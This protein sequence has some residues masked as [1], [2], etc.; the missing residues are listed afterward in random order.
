V[1]SCLDAFQSIVTTIAV[2]IGAYAALSGLNTWREQLRG[3]T[4][5]ELARRLMR[6]ALD[7]RDMANSFRHPAIG[8]GEMLDALR[9][10]GIDPAKVDLITDKRATPLVYQRRW[11]RVAKAMS[12][13]HVEILEAEVLWGD[14]PRECE[15]GLRRAVHPLWAAMT[16]R[17]GRERPDSPQDEGARKR[18][19]E[20]FHII[21]AGSQEPDATAEAITAA[22][23]AF[24]AVVKPHLT[25]RRR[26]T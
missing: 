4:E 14:S 6:S 2:G 7:V 12:D 15:E 11:S 23:R 18:E 13:L 19:Q 1:S 16:M 21:Y 22:V 3:K 8:G 17:F 9:E 5:Y 26:P 20:Q 10:S 25:I 24:E